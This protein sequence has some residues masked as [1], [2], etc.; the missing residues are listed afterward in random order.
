VAPADAARPLYK[1][2]QLNSLPVGLWDGTDDQLEVTAWPDT[3]FTAFLL[4]KNTDANLGSRFLETANPA[5][6]FVITGN[7]YTGTERSVIHVGLGNATANI[8]NSM[9]WNIIEIKR[10]GGTYTLTVNGTNIGTYDTAD[11]FGVVS[12]GESPEAYPDWW[13]AGNAAQIIRYSTALSGIECAK[14]RHYL[15]TTFD[16]DNV[17]YTPYIPV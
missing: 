11:N 3:D 7:L 1:T 6:Y 5:A 16:I 4:V 17:N 12:I 8:V 14:V 13:I 9:G 15:A 10:S 2:N